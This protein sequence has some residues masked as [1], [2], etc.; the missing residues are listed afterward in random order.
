M[1]QGFATS[2]IMA[3]CAYGLRNALRE[4]FIDEHWYDWMKTLKVIE[5]VKPKLT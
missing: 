3:K 5:D 2:Y 4:T 1:Q